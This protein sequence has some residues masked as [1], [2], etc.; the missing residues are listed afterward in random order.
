LTAAGGRGGA[1]LGCAWWE[2]RLAG[3]TKVLL[4]RAG[5]ELARTNVFESAL[6]SSADFGNPN[7]V[8]IE[9]N[10][11]DSVKIH[12]SRRENNFLNHKKKLLA[13]KT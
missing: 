9:F 2:E 4:S 3:R 1:W 10:K 5:R 7:S 11:P 8:S 6:E 13:K 12:S